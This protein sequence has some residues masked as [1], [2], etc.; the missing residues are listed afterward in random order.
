MNSLVVSYKPDSKILILTLDSF[1]KETGGRTEYNHDLSIFHEL[2]DLS[3]RIIEVRQKIWSL[4]NKDK[5]RWQ[6]DTDELIINQKLLNAEDFGGN[7]TG[8]SFLPA[9]YRYTGDFY[10]T[11]GDEGKQALLQS[12]H[13]FLIVSACYGLL[14]PTEQIQYYA[15]Q[16]GD[17][18]A[19]F[20]RWVKDKKEITKILVEYLKKHKIKRIFDFTQCAV[21]A[22]QKA[23]S[24]DI[25]YQVCPE[26]SVYHAYSWIQNDRSLRVF[27]EFISRKML[28]S[29]EEDLLKIE[30]DR[31]MGNFKFQKKLPD[32]TEQKTSDIDPLNLILDADESDTVE[33]KTSAFGNLTREKVLTLTT[34]HVQ[35]FKDIVD[36]KKIAKTLCA[37]MNS[38][39]GDLF[40]GVEGRN[41]LNEKNIITGID[42]EMTK[43]GAAGYRADTDGYERLIQDG[44]VKVFIPEYNPA[45][46]RIKYNFIHPDGRTICCINVK[47]SKRPMFMK[48]YERNKDC[49]YIRDGRKSEPL[50]L[51]KT[52]EYILVHFCPKQ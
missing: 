51:K 27:A 5:V 52:A 11:L 6:N 50:D 24:W 29:S 38:D 33:F 9:I 14:K 44:I 21:S 40:I 46:K 18:N 31:D 13:H 32:F 16:F 43:V 26:I 3:E 28:S 37:F 10:Q 48:S 47:S 42:S 7:A 20:R 25:V 8:A 12:K 4:L 39:G 2:P 49:F 19:A 45:A 15:C 22:Y 23:I 1:F 41:S 17:E 30:L 36:C 34:N 35:I